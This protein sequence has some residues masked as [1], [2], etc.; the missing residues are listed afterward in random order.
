MVPLS[1]QYLLLTLNIPTTFLFCYFINKIEV[2]LFNA[3]GSVITLLG[4]FVVGTS[5]FVE[6]GQTSNSVLFL[7]FR[8]TR[9]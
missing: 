7:S 5:G 3:G 6:K 2:T 4:V 8:K 9:F 1:T